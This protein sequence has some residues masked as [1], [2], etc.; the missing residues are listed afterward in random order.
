MC[1][2]V[3]DS[4]GVCTGKTVGRSRGGLK[5][6]TQ[7]WLLSYVLEIGALLLL[8]FLCVIGCPYAPNCVEVEMGSEQLMSF[9]MIV[10]GNDDM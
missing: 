6:V 1:V 2:L 8:R 4:V 9:A 5:W 3:C 10:F 7:V